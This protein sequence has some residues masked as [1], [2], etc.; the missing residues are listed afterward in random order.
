M[1]LPQSIGGLCGLPLA[2]GAQRSDMGWSLGGQRLKPRMVGL[3]GGSMS[4]L[5][6]IRYTVPVWEKSVPRWEGTSHKKAWSL[7]PASNGVSF[8]YSLASSSEHTPLAVHSAGVLS[9][10]NAAPL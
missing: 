6:E 8:L 1:W 2:D 5:W 10:P 3:S 9:I 7:Q 4:P